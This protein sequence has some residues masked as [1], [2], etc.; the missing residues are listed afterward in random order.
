VRIRV[1]VKHF[2]GIVCRTVQYTKDV[3][4]CLFWIFFVFSVCFEWVAFFSDISKWI[5][6][7]E[8]N[9][10]NRKNVLLVS[11]NKPKINRN[12]LSFGLFRFEPK[13]FLFCFE[14]TLILGHALYRGPKF[15]FSQFGL[16][17]YQKTQDTL[18][19]TTQGA[20]CVQTEFFILGLLFLGAFCH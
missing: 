9:W 11:R 18:L 3:F 2:N 13:N 6:N 20:P 16:H 15:V 7:T 19:H 14:D 5:R 4:F 12:R 17:G 10:N 1:N 8:T